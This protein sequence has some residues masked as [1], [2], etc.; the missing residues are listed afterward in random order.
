VLV[1]LI[2]HPW[3]AFFRLR[4]QSDPYVKF[5]LEQDN[6]IMDKD[7]GSRKSS[8][9]AGTFWVR[10]DAIHSILACYLAVVLTSIVFPFF[11]LFFFLPNRH[12]QSR[13]G[14]IV[15]LYLA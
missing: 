9:K 5:E 11:P 1:F 15:H 6:M 10:F 3:F 12:R 8:S 14:R 13:L 7:F 2:A 4:Y